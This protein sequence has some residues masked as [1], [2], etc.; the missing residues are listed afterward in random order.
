MLIRLVPVRDALVSTPLEWKELTDDLDPRD[1]TIKTAPARS[2]KVG[3]IWAAA[4]KEAQFAEGAKLAVPYFS[5]R[6]LYLAGVAGGNALRFR[7]G[8]RGVAGLVNHVSE[9]VI[10]MER[11]HWS[12]EAS[13]SGA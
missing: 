5:Q 7:R 3:D 8:E 11:V 9:L 12:H 6:Q 2:A 13:S 4:L 1:F 10:Q